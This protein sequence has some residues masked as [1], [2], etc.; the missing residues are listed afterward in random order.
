[1]TS[2]IELPLNSI[3]DLQSLDTLLRTL[4]NTTAGA[5]CQN[6]LTTEY[7]AWRL[8]VG[9]ILQSAHG[10]ASGL[11]TES[12]L[13]PERLEAFLHGFHLQFSPPTCVIMPCVPLSTI[14]PG[15]RK[16]KTAKISDVLEFRDI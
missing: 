5:Q 12:G 3:S 4:S 6:L 7:Q 1:M 15:L 11:P 16:R 9:M 13:S 14:A 10:T 2:R 8:R